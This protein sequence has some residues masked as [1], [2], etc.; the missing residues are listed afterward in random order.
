MLTKEEQKRHDPGHISPAKRT[1]PLDKSVGKESVTVG[2]VKLIHTVF[3]RNAPN[4]KTMTGLL[5]T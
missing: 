5:F 1:D 3:R 2:A 4:I